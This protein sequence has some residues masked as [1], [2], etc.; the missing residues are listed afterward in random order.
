[1]ATLG[2]L[3][4]A[5]SA[6]LSQLRAGIDEAIGYFDELQEKVDTLSDSLDEIQE[7][8]SGF[9]IDIDSESVDAASDSVA[10]LSRSISLVSGSAFKSAQAAVSS[11]GDAAREALSLAAT[12]DLAAESGAAEIVAAMRT[13]AAT[14]GEAGAA[15]RGALDGISQTARS[16]GDAINATTVDEF[17][18]AMGRAAE[19]TSDFKFSAENIISRVVVAFVAAIKSLGDQAGGF[20]NITRALS[21]DLRGTQVVFAALSKSAVSFIASISAYSAVV[22]LAKVLTQDL[23]EESQGYALALARIIGVQ[24]GFAAGSQAASASAQAITT[25][26][27]GATTSLQAFTN[28]LSA[29]PGLLT[30]ASASGGDLA[31]QLGRV[32]FAFQF[33]AEAASS[34]RSAI[35][36]AEIAARGAAAAAAM[37]AVSGAVAA[38]ASGTSILGGATAGALAGLTGFAAI[39]P[40]VTAFAALAAVATGEF[41]EE[42]E[43][44]SDQA[45]RLKNLAFQF[46]T[47]TQEIER[48][49][50]AAESA[51]VSLTS[52]AR[53][54]QEFSQNVSKI[55]IG[56]LD[57]PETSDA[58]SGFSR[59]GISIEQ[60]RG[61][62]PDELFNLVAQRLLEVED[63]ADRTGIALD[64]FGSTGAR[65]IPALGGLDEIAAD[66][67]RLNVAT[68]SVDIAS[69]NELNMSFDRA[70]RASAQLSQAGLLAFSS[71]QTGINNFLADVRGGLAAFVTEGGRA[72]ADFTQPIATFL[73]VLGRV[74]NVILRI[75]ASVVKL[76]SAFSFFPVV[77]ALAEL[78]G[79]AMM[80]LLTIVESIADGF[81]DAAQAIYDQFVPSFDAATMSMEELSK[82]IL[83]V[84]SLLAAGV[85]ATGMFNAALIALG[86]SPGAVIGRLVKLI[87]TSLVGA[88]RFLAVNS[89]AAF[90]A[91]TVGLVRTS[92][93][94]VTNATLIIGRSIAMGVATFTSWVAPSLAAMVAYTTGMSAT[95]AASTAA[96]LV[97][98]AAWVTATLG[99][100]LIPLALIAIYQNFDR[101]YDFFANFGDNISSLMS[102]DGI[103]N[104]AG[105][106]AQAVFDAFISI[107][108]GV[109]GFIGRIIN[110]IVNAFSGIEAPPAIDAAQ[111]TTAELLAAR[112]EQMEVKRQ[113]VRNT[114][115]AIA[116]GASL[117]TGGAYS[118]ESIEEGQKNLLIEEPPEEDYDALAQIID[119]ANAGLQDLSLSAARFGGAASEAALKAQAEWQELR[120]KFAEGDISTEEFEA[121]AQKIQQTFQEQINLVDAIGPA[122]IQKL[123]ES[124]QEDIASAR[125]AIRD[126][127]ADTEVED[128]FGNVQ[129]FPASDEIKAQAEQFRAEYEAELTDIAERAAAGEFGEG[130]EG[131]E[132][133]ADARAEAERKFKRNQDALSRDTSFANSIRKQLEEAFLTPLQKYE[134]RLSQ[135]RNNQSL[136]PEEKK[137][138]ED[139]LRRETAEATF[140]RTAAEEIQEKR[141]L[142]QF[143]P[144]ERQAAATRGL[145]AERRQAAGVE[146]TALQQLELGTDKINDAFGTAGLTIEEIQAKLSPQEFEEYQKAIENN[147]KAV[148]QSLGVEQTGA[149]K[150]AESRERLDKAFDDGVITAQERDD[151]IKK[152]RDDLL[153][154]LGIKKSPAEQFETAVEKIEKNAAELTDDEMAEAMKEAKDNLL[155]ALGIDESPTAQFED[156]MDDLNEALNK[157]KISQEEFAEGAKKAKDALLQSLGIPLDPVAQFGER[158]SDLDE[159]L[160]ANK[161]S[162]EEYNLGIEEAK[163]SILPGGEDESPVKVFRRQMEQIDRAASQNLIG[164]GEANERRQRLQ[165]QLQEDLKPALDQLAPDRRGVEGSDVRSKGGV[166]TFFRILRGR[167]NPSLK[168]Q[169]DTARNTKLI[170]EAMSEPDA[171]PVIAQLGAY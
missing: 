44:L 4:V 163:R 150:L 52:L 46:G 140:G 142:V 67:R 137:R 78:V 17:V 93:A 71:L 92:I 86:V 58:A 59:L 24:V 134:R 106:A 76:V 165:A 47:V 141:E 14:S 117:M 115:R 26:I 125:T 112:S 107:L 63:A 82:G 102:F 25:A 20:S 169:L 154:S 38:L 145:D 153:S 2:S 16:A 111:A 99:L 60:I 124:I 29:T 65:I 33:I 94:W 64:I 168:A 170:A 88:V 130:Q 159:A 54:Q 164:E 3:S 161:I 120:Q 19:A 155:D 37:G 143:L 1:M 45:E 42:L 131:R 75:A 151:T 61:L 53:A 103:V 167:D 166:D 121:A 91:I 136:T 41:S 156:R 138:A 18:S 122:E 110:S 158:L 68:S 7:K 77:A 49:R 87:G 69:L 50:F 81:A 70:S 152:Q 116:V 57:L 139:N 15:A 51:N 36:L 79:E 6:D 21:G 55:R 85:V 128:S 66:M 9:S 32:S 90:K 123:F 144:P 43:T 39:I 40:Q 34:D 48:F 105:E 126:L 27:S 118:P 11:F 22:G 135:I 146:N 149:D 56:Q 96:S 13:I 12:G 147:Q 72:F 100:A 171:A 35:T 127:T 84:I 157:G 30:R 114:N 104:L 162:Q 101:I 132:N 89:L 80:R 10:E 95:A 62:A 31:V 108:T 133:I 8:S 23:S 98:A 119:S 113:E 148:K 28:V 109:G 83:K 160:A 74:I 129:L 5:F 97:M 73:E